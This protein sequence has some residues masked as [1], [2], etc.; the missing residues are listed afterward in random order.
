MSKKFLVVGIS[1]ILALSTMLSG[2]SGGSST[3]KPGTAS[4]SGN[5]LPSTPVFDVVSDAASVKLDTKGGQVALKNGAKLVIPAG[6][7]TRS[8]AVGLK[9]LS[10]PLGF[11]ND[12]TA[13][14][15]T[16]LSGVTGAVTLVFPTATGHKAEELEVSRYNAVSKKYESVPFD[17]DA[18]SG[19]VTVT[20]STAK[21]TARSSGS[22]LM[23][24][25][26]ADVMGVIVSHAANRIKLD[27]IS[28]ST[29]I[30]WNM[31]EITPPK[32]T[33]HEIPM[34]YYVQVGGD[35]GSADLLM[36]LRGYEPAYNTQ[37][38][39]DV[40]HAL[41]SGTWMPVSVVPA[42]WI[43]GPIDNDFG[44]DAT[45]KTSML[46]DYM[47]TQ[48]GIANNVIV[49][50]LSDQMHVWYKLCYNLDNDTPVMLEYT[51]PGHFVLVVGYRDSGKTFLIHDSQGQ[52]N[53]MYTVRPW[54]W[55]WDKMTPD[56][57]TTLT[58]F[59]YPLNPGYSLQSIGCP[60]GGDTSPES[61]VGKLE[62]GTSNP[63]LP[64]HYNQRVLLRFQPSAE[65]GYVWWDSDNNKTIGTIPSTADLLHID[66]PVWN[67]DRA[68][69][70]NVG[71]D[72]KF[73]TGS[74]QVGSYHY[75]AT[76]AAATDNNEAINTIK[77]NILLVQNDASVNIR[78][79]ELA[80]KD[81]NQKLKIDV[82][83]SKGGT[84]CDGFTLNTQLSV[85][86]KIVQLS[87]NSSAPSLPV[88]I[89]GV[90]FGKDETAG[91]K[92]TVGGKEAKITFWSDQRVEINVPDDMAGGDQPVIVTA[93]N[94]SSLPVNLTIV[95]ALGLKINNLSLSS[96]SPGISVDING[97][98]FGN[99]QALFNTVWVGGVDGVGGVKAK[100]LS[101]TGNKITVEIPVIEAGV[102]PVYVW[103]GDQKEYKSNLVNFNVG[104]ITLRIDPPEINDAKNDTPYTFT[105]IIDHP[106]SNAFCVWWADGM[107]VSNGG[108]VNT[109][110]LPF[111]T[112]GTHSIR[113]ELVVWKNGIT[114]TVIQA[115]AQVTVKN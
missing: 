90:A 63:K 36:M 38:A 18:P 1:I 39:G 65:S 14:N 27:A 85:L 93:G 17:F 5:G 31:T 111:R 62:F 10:N 22:G 21:T 58:W 94:F 7:L 30:I 92:V 95:S 101:W 28:D 33:E 9:Q 78:R 110:T 113:V 103:A 112:I 87:P 19:N 15:V 60:G 41:Y 61:E 67:A 23:S 64:G 42:S 73:S 81:G 96:G 86:P 72:V 45:S 69:S 4:V 83:L 48:T 3:A 24:S 44:F 88:I 13:Y 56:T 97:S 32:K 40:M 53:E 114:D 99:A 109:L 77:D 66:L 75:D 12:S 49:T 34:P 70:A 100:I 11:G 84:F 74:T 57:P 51:K 102:Q 76:L 105:A 43:N 47:H 107:Q 71:I 46:N 52:G 59:K 115:Q 104:A 16:G 79:P 35:C 37:T 80:D 26:V 108:A 50:S 6:S 29:E 20:I 91:N 54:T 106:A 55:V 8:V 98:G 82:A 25:L 2:C 68:S 89:N